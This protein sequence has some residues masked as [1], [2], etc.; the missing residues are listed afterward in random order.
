M[1][2]DRMRHLDRPRERDRRRYRS[3]SRERP[4]I[5]DRDRPRTTYSGSTRRP[6]LRSPAR[7]RTGYEGLREFESTRE[8]RRRRANDARPRKRRR[9]SCEGRRFP[10]KGIAPVD[11]LDEAEEEK[12]KKRLA[13]FGTL[14]KPK[15][16]EVS[17]GTKELTSKEDKNELKKVLDKKKDRSLS[18]EMHES[19]GESKPTQSSREDK[20]NENESGLLDPVKDVASVD[21]KSLSSSPTKNHTEP[22]ESGVGLLVPVEAVSQRVADREEDAVEKRRKDRLARFGTTKDPKIEQ[23]FKP[24]NSVEEGDNMRPLWR[25]GRARSRDRDHRESSTKNEE[26]GRRKSPR[27]DN[28]NDTDFL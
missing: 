26:E 2:S 18:R 20:A 16:N 13:R 1:F 17:N 12:R 8:I 21:D 15:I 4:R 25:D 9:V 28:T 10:D 19:A 23:P 22:E 5:R 11:N 6:R 7:R 14:V 24:K 27:E 3:R